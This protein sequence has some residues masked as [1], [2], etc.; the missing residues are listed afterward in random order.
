VTGAR[1]DA[2]R[3]ALVAAGGLGNLAI[4]GQRDTAQLPGWTKVRAMKLAGA[5]ALARRL[6]QEVEPARRRL[7]SPD[8]VAAFMRDQLRGL[9]Q[10]ELWAIA[11][12]AKNAVLDSWQVSRGLLDRSPCHAREVYRRAIVSS[13]ARIVLCHNHPSGDPSPS[14]LDIAC[15]R[16]MVEAGK[17]VG[18][19]VADHIIM[20]RASDERPRDYC[21]LRELGLI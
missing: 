7:T 11:L 15:T 19:E 4:V 8:A 3:G 16:E 17:L 2:V 9:V 1:L 10:E 21:S 20:G 18:I 13:A 14:R 5:F 12:N 6:S